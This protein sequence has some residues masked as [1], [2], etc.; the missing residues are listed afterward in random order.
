MVITY[1]YKVSD[2]PYIALFPCFYISKRELE[3]LSANHRG[4][5]AL[6]Y[7]NF[8]GCLAKVTSTTIKLLVYYTASDNIAELMENT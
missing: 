7:K 8:F 6:V 1:V 5:K 3:I 2:T 4:K